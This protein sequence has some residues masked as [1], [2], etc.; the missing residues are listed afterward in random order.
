M[1]WGIGILVVQTLIL[2]ALAASAFYL[3]EAV[4]Q[5]GAPGDLVLQ[6]QQLEGQFGIPTEQA[7][8]AKM[9][10]F[11]GGYLPMVEHRIGKWLEPFQ[12]TLI[13]GW[14]TLAYFLFGMAL[15]KSGFFLGAWEPARYRRLVL[16][17]FGVG[18]PA[19][20]AIAFFLYCDGFSVPMILACAMGATTPFRPLMI[21]ATASL[22]ILLARRGGALADRIAAAG[23]VAFSN[24]L[25]T[26]ILMTSLFYGYG[27]GL[28]GTLGRAQLWLVVLAGWALMLLWSK[29]WLDRFRYGPLEWLWRSLARGRIEPFRRAPAAV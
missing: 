6:W 27:L 5:P 23:R 12:A 22:I 13:F 15:L 10:M 29:P 7:L 20:A 21:L 8:A 1:H 26:S 3:R 2:A 11:H 14:E 9:S 24:Y 16:I 4:S 17:G 25:G 28:Y 18:V 19:Y